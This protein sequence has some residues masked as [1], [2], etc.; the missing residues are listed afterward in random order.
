MEDVYL[1]GVSFLKQMAGSPVLP[2]VESRI[3]G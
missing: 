1:T 2:L 3:T